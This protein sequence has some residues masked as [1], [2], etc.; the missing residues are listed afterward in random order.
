MLSAVLASHFPFTCS[1]LH[2]TDNVTSDHEQ[3]F[4]TIHCKVATTEEPWN[5]GSSSFHWKRLPGDKAKT[6]STVFV[7]HRITISV[8]FH[9]IL[10]HLPLLLPLS[11]LP[12]S[13]HTHKR[14]G[15]EPILSSFPLSS[16]PFSILY[17]HE[18][19][20]TFFSTHSVHSISCPFLKSSSFFFLTTNILN[21]DGYDGACLFR[22][23]ASDSSH[24]F[25]SS[26]R[27]S[28]EQQ[29]KPVTFFS[30]FQIRLNQLMIK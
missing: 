21:R 5:A 3:N 4:Y 7:S 6:L 16:V 25:S 17:I 24:L 23:K 22:L 18:K 9:S 30:I 26:R 12:S 1:S 2:V 8:L 28:Q 29:L 10:H 20:K 14:R 11:F 19:G 15:I 13:Q 27:L